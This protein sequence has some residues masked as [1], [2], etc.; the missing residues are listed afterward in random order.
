MLS[1]KGKFIPNYFL[2]FHLHR[3][4]PMD[5]FL[6]PMMA[7]IKFFVM[8]IVFLQSNQHD[9]QALER[10]FLQTNSTKTKPE[11]TKIYFI[12]IVVLAK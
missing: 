5:P 6:S 10:G 12:E 8:I 9:N 4:Q 3:I 2:L 11:E 1:Q 7:K